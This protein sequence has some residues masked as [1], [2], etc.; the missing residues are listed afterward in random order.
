MMTFEERL[1]AGKKPEEREAFRSWCQ[2]AFDGPEGRAVLAA[3]CAAAHPMEHS[4]ALTDHDH[5]RREVIATLW[6]YGAISP[7]PPTLPAA[8]S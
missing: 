4:P 1:F 6:R 2:K 5:G 8:Q 7:I 3:L